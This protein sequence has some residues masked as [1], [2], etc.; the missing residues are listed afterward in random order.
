MAL[1]IYNTLTRRKE[2]FIPLHQG[3][4][5]MY[6]CGPTV[7]SDAHL[8]HAKSYIS[9][10]IIVRYLIYLGYRVKYV[11]NLT[12]VGHLLDTG[13]DRI[14]MGAKRE[15]LDPM[16]L[17]ENY[18][19][20]YFEDMDAL[21]VLAP[22]ISP[23][24]TAHILE[25]IELI[26]LLLQ[27]G[28]AYKINGSVYFDITKFP[29]YGKLSGRKIEDQ[30]AGARVEIRDEKQHPADFV[31]WVKAT[32]EHI[33][34]WNSPWG[35]GYPGW[36]IECSAMAMKY[37]GETLDIHG[38]GMEN[39]FPHHECEIAQSEAA[40][41][42]QFVRYW[43]HNNMIL[44]NGVKMSK[45]LGNF[46][47]IRDALNK[48]SPEQI[49]FF[50]LTTHYR[51][52]VDFS[53]AAIQGAGEG[54]RKLQTTFERLSEI[55]RYAQN[56]NKETGTLKINKLLDEYKQK[57]ME[58]MDDDFNT[59]LAIGVLFDLSRELNAYLD[60]ETQ[61]SKQTITAAYQLYDKLGSEI[62]GLTLYSKH[63]LM[64]ADK[65]IE[66]LIEIR[67]D[68]RSIKQ[69]ELADKIPNFLPSSPSLL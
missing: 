49:R 64:E 23:R 48:Y 3:E 26:E 4:V 5:R 15:K 60:K 16:E 12:D 27:K 52:P 54:M 44:V 33:M 46:T 22:N 19:R 8:G 1:K 30:V 59:P 50:I 42:K 34:Q 66:L 6:V 63:T 31:L 67:N 61:V 36:H 43:V 21:N 32:P 20:R 13:E 37:L 45:S 24:A 14:L 62:L 29:S 18:I 69:W 11:Q 39:M 56:D 53:D 68:L 38:G 7:Y 10:D 47:I 28:Y 17:V 58:A 51:S 40:T 57:F 41:G 55:L 25:Q 35:K 2:E 65:Y 9:F